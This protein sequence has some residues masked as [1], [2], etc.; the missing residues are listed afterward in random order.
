M[1][2]TDVGFHPD[3]RVPAR[4]PDFYRISAATIT[5]DVPILDQNRKVMGSRPAALEL[6]DIPD[7][8]FKDQAMGL[9]RRIMES[10]GI[11]FEEVRP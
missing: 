1:A 6:A 3:D 9:V 10:N 7:G 11:R 4:V 2:N 5:V 8:E